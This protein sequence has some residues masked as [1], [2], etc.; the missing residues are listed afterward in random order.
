M[1][2]S[3]RDVTRARSERALVSDPLAA[4]PGAGYRPHLDGLR[5]VAVYLVV[6]FHAG[7]DRAAGGFIGVDVFFVLSGYLVTQLLL[8]DLRGTGAIDLRRFYG[9]RARRLLPAALVALVVTMVVFSSIASPAELGDATDATRAAALYVSNWFF[10]AESAQYFGS[11]VSASPVAHFWSLSVEEQYYVAWP[12]ML[13]GLH[14]LA[15]R[16]GARRWAVLRGAV[17]AGL[18]AS[19]SA[20]L[21]LSRSNLDRAY[22]GTDTRAYQLLA[23]A[24]LALAPD[25]ID[26]LGARSAA[27]RAV[28]L[29]ATGAM[30]GLLLLATD[31]VDV[32][33]VSRGVWAAALAVA[34]IGALEMAPAG[35]LRR[36]LS[37]PAIVY[38]GRISYGT[39]LWHWLV[40]VVTIR[41]VG[42]T[43]TSTA[44][45]TALVATGVA[46]LSFELV[47]RPVREAR[48]LDGR[49]SLVVAVAVAASLAVGLAVAPRVLAHPDRPA[50]VEVAQGTADGGTQVPVD[51]D[52]EGAQEDLAD[53]PECTAAA[54]ASCTLVQGSGPRLMLIGDSHARMFIPMLTDLARRRG[55]SFSAAVAPVC[56]WHDGLQYYRRVDECRARQAE[57]YPTLVELLDPDLVVLA[58]RTFD[59]PLSTVRLVDDAGEVKLGSAD[60]L[61]RIRESAAATLQPLSAADRRTVIIEPLPVAAKGTDPLVCLSAAT[62]LDECR[63][64]THVGATPI[65]QLYRDLAVRDDRVWTID[66]D[67]HVCPYLPICD[68]IVDGLIVKRDDTHLT[69][70]FA[71]TLLGVFERFLDDNAIVE[72][73]EGGRQ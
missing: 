1:T 63:Y 57:W 68:P 19:L 28:Q 6:L 31:L 61:D 47:E 14:A 39:Y 56:P 34:V 17:L 44:L 49:G 2:A 59:D 42:A 7:A 23:G 71:R 43:P 41:V 18:L 60:G 30:G 58:H 52:W 66:L 48:R 29:V 4:P 26:R 40:V 53:F 45:V 36:A 72:R 20:A 67:G 13:A 37:M 50:A 5:A 62:F 10:I 65:E 25:I 3:L 55:L 70:R 12:L 16:A 73:E 21:L 64:V 32:D 11:D 15:G 24:L 54:V 35:M 22:Y 51:L 69:T 8:R 9:R 46:A 33:P 38:L 27:R